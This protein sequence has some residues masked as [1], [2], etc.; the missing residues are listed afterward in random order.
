VSERE[1]AVIRVAAAVLQS[2]VV[3]MVAESASSGL[4]QLD[5]GR[6]AA[7]VAILA[8]QVVNACESVAAKPV[9]SGELT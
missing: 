7:A 5:T 6:F 8:V 9:P 2:P 3:G 4:G 1:Q